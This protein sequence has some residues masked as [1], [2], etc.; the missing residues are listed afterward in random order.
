VAAERITFSL[1]CSLLVCPSFLAP[2]LRLCISFLAVYSFFVVLNKELG[3]G[4]GRLK[5]AVVVKCLA[6]SSA[7]A[8]IARKRQLVVKCLAKSS[9]NVV[10]ARRRQLVVKCLVKSLEKTVVA[11][12]Q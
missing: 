11:R 8:V 1:V 6:K 4:S 7:D 2:F 9:A 3:K 12:R 5:K 10:I